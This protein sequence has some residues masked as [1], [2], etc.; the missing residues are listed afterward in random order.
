MSIYE[1]AIR[2]EEDGAAFYRELAG[3]SPN[4]AVQ[5]VLRMLAEEEDKHAQAVRAMAA[6]EP[7][8]PIGADVLKNARTIF[9]QMR[10][11]GEPFVTETEQIHLYHKALEIEEKS[12][13]FY[14]ARAA[15]MK[16]ARA[17]QLFERLA[18]EEQK[19]A[20]LLDNVIELVSRPKQWL[21]NAEFFHQEEY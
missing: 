2:M 18:A 6:E 9:R 14:L 21:E 10:N 12:R 5:S 16:Q 19:H 11:K 7:E 4:P 1:F 13:A 3:K 17:K 15:E 8:E 20:E